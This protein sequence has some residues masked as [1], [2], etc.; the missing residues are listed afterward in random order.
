MEENPL[1]YEI[2]PKPIKLEDSEVMEISQSNK[3]VNPF[4]LSLN[5]QVI[6]ET[7]KIDEERKK[8]ELD[9]VRIEGQPKAI[10]A[11]NSMARKF[12]LGAVNMKVAAYRDKYESYLK[13][14]NNT[15]QKEV[16]NIY[17]HV[18]N[19]LMKEALNE[20]LQKMVT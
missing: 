12:K 19:E 10:E 5:A 2:Q 11:H 3:Y 18:A 8:S 6:L 15:S 7:A 4:D 17:D 14:H 9:V 20:V 13:L 1:F 16:W